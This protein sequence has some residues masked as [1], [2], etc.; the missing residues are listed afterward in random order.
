MINEVLNQ[1]DLTIELLKMLKY[2]LYIMKKII[3]NVV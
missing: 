2:C 3:F 1:N